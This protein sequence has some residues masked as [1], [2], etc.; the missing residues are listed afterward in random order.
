MSALSAAADSNGSFDVGLE[1]EA[2]KQLGIAYMD[3][4]VARKAPGF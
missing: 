3:M 1:A 2:Q 4:P